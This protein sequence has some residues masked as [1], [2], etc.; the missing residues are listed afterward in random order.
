M[1]KLN[2]TVGFAC[3]YISRMLGL[4]TIYLSDLMQFGCS[5][6]Y[7][8]DLLTPNNPSCIFLPF[9]IAYCQ[10]SL[11]QGL[12][13]VKLCLQSDNLKLKSMHNTYHLFLSDWCR[14]LPQD[15][16]MMPNPPLKILCRVTIDTAPRP[17][18]QV[19]ITQEPAY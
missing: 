7:S 16:M 18:V 11:P 10:L 1:Y 2:G 6:S 19:L 5:T 3:L 9:T 4:P 8:V 17:S 12:I 15:R 14:P 13:A